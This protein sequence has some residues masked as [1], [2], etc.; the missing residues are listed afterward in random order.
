MFSDML[1]EKR[2]CEGTIPPNSLKG[3][4]IPDRPYGVTKQATQQNI[5]ISVW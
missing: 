2:L 3:S 4:R 5:G 1:R